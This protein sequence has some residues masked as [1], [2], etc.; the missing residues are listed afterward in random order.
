M[1]HRMGQRIPVDHA[2]SL[3]FT[4]KGSIDGRLVNISLTGAAIRCSDWNLL[5]R[6]TP[7][8][9]KLQSDEESEAKPISIQGFVVRIE[10]G[11]IGIMFMRDAFDLFKRFK[12]DQ[13]QTD[14]EQV[15]SLLV[16]DM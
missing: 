5:V 8:V 4:E 9:I 6:Y 14:R 3:Y 11:L 1:N 2:I 12:P 10:D 7:V 13:L 16:A 15:Q